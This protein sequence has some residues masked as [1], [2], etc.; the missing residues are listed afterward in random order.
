M[1]SY[2][3]LTCVDILTLCFHALI[4]CVDLSFTFFH[5]SIPLHPRITPDL[6]LYWPFASSLLSLSFALFLSLSL[7]HTHT[8]TRLHTA[9]RTSTCMTATHGPPLLRQC[10]CSDA[11]LLPS[12]PE[13]GLEGRKL[14]TYIPNIICSKGFSS[15]LLYLKI[16]CF[17]RTSAYLLP[18]ACTRPHFGSRG[19]TSPTER[20]WRDCRTNYG[21][22]AYA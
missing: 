4:L 13:E 7:S 12:C 18:W 6:S 15:I 21:S 8:H 9:R 17:T 14:G 22:S 1:S 10:L 11:S 20:Q 5:S 3:V 2:L 16:C 19:D